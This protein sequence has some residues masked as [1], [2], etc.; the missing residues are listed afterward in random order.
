MA[1][2]TTARFSAVGHLK[3]VLH[4][5]SKMA[6][7]VRMRDRSVKVLQYGCQ[8]LIHYYGS[9]LQASTLK[10]LS[11][12]RRASSSSRKAFWLLKSLNHVGTLVSM[13]EGGMLDWSTPVADKL[14]LVEQVFLVLY[15]WYESEIYFARAD[16][17]GLDEDVIDPWCNWTWFGGDLAFFLACVVRLHEHIKARTLLA[18]R[19]VEAS[20]R[21]GDVFDDDLCVVSSTHAG[22]IIYTYSVSQVLSTG[23]TASGVTI[24]NNSEK[25]REHQLNSAVAMPEKFAML[26]ELQRMD[27]ETFDK[28][29]ALAIGVLEL[30]VS[31][32]YVDF[33]KFVF[34]KHIS[35]A[36]VGAMGVSSS[37][38]ILYEGLLAYRRELDGGGN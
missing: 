21:D 15:Y 17:F 34:G 28:Q 23:L 27:R 26:K 19:L 24:V 31:L 5:W 18:K 37:L 14:D 29:L 6:L 3:T 25:G 7:N 22:D 20:K 38:L 2:T 12:L 16:L 8:M 1:T 30:G 13:V 10:S 33:Y 11:T 35:E 9:Q 32:H 4:L 36:Y